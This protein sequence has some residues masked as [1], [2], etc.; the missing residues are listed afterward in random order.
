[1]KRVLGTW[2]AAMLVLGAFVASANASVCPTT[3]CTFEFNK[4]STL[5]NQNYGTVA[6]VLGTGTGV[7][8]N[9]FGCV[10]ALR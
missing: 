4:A 2:S 3:S 6:L 7:G 9:G 5:G 10:S 1:M 8:G